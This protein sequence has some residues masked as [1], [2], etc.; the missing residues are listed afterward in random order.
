METATLGVIDAQIGLV[1]WHPGPRNAEERILVAML[2]GA[3]CRCGYRRHA[4]TS[5][6]DHYIRV[7]KDI[8]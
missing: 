7:P 3:L 4:E 1:R 8:R 6:G 5:L 2:E